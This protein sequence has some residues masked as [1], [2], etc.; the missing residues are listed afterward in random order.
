MPR[1][2]PGRKLNKG[3]P[4]IYNRPNLWRLTPGI[5]L[6]TI[7]LTNLIG[8]SSLSYYSQAVAGQTALLWHRKDIALI[9][10][11]PDT[12]ESIKKKLQL[13]TNLLEYAEDSLGFPVGDTYSS[14]VETGKP[15]IVWNVFAA[16]EFSLQMET[17]CYPIAGCVSYRGYFDEN[18]AN[19]YAATLKDEGYDV[20]VGGVAA[21]STLGWFSDPVLDTFLR[22]SDVNIARL[23]FH[24]LAHKIVYLQGDTQFNESFAVAIEDLS[25]RRW[26][27]DRG[28]E[29]SYQKYLSSRVRRAEVLV[30]IKETRDKLNEIYL[31]SEVDADKRHQ[32]DIA[33]KEL[34]SAY[35]KQQARWDGATD[36]E[37]WMKSEINNA[38]LGTLADYNGWVAAFQ[39]ILV[40]NQGDIDKFTDAIKRLSKLDRKDR[41]DY[42]S[43]KTPGL[44]RER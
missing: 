18:R 5:I 17:F 31:H 12:D 32:K 33:I 40:E 8:C 29:V 34:R 39:Q 16:P 25:L 7:L 22:R 24:E 21:Y 9:I 19:Q 6:A 26:L 42:L 43:D 14:Y 2:T 36:Y 10:S 11:D 15:Y 28:E 37:Y 3:T 30:L 35:E 20:F 41:D 4:Q 44:V 38:K 1:T 13:V 27:I 23:L